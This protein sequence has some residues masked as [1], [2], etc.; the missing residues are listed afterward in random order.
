VTTMLTLSGTS[1]TQ[2]RMVTLTLT[3]Q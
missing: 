2:T 3:V 1:G